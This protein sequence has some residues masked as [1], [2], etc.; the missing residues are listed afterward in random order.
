MPTVNAVIH[1]AAAMV[2]LIVL[3]GFMFYHRKNA[4]LQERF[5]QAM[6]VGK[7][8]RVRAESLDSFLGE[9][10]QDLGCSWDV[11]EDTTGLS[12]SKI[13]ETKFLELMKGLQPTRMSLWRSKQ[14]NLQLTVG[15]SGK[16]TITSELSQP[17]ADSLGGQIVVT[18]ER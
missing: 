4:R 6:G 12:L 8:Q 9:F 11:A 18:L 7:H 3:Y 10:T 16:V 5:Q 13:H 17:I 14:G 2:C 1:L 15:I